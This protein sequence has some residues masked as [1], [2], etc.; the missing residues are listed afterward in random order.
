MVPPSSRGRLV[1][2]SAKHRALRTED[3]GLRHPRLRHRPG[4]SPRHKPKLGLTVNFTPTKRLVRDGRQL[5]HPIVLAGSDV[6]R[7]G[8]SS[9]TRGRCRQPDPSGQASGAARGVPTSGSPGERLDQPT[10][11]TRKPTA[12]VRRT[13]SPKI[14]Q[15][16]RSLVRQNRSS[17]PCRPNLPAPK[18]LPGVVPVL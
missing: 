8:E 4:G 11:I 18:R 9:T 17:Q 5:E 3:R 7:A 13:L 14:A 10:Y 1:V 6:D 15:V 12:E 16:L 2:K